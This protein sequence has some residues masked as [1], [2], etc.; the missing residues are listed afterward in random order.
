MKLKS[1]PLVL[2]SAA[3]S[4][5]LIG[6]SEG[7]EQGQSST[8]ESGGK[9]K[10]TF[11]H[12]MTDITGDAVKA[13]I[14]AFEEKNP[15]I[16]IEATYIA[17]QG[18]GQ[19]EK[20]MA[21]VAGGNPPDV[22]YFD[23]FEVGAWA[24][25]GSLEELTALAQK[26]GITK[27]QYY[28][29][30]WEESS[31]QDKLYAIP[32]T[33]DSR[34]VYFNV[35]HFKE[36]G[37]DP[38]NPPKTIADL[39][40]AASKLTK[41]DGK[42]FERIGFIPWFGQGSLYGWGWAFGGEFYDAAANK[43]TANHPK[44]VEALQ[45]LA[46]YAKKYNVEDISAFTDSQGTGAMDPFLTGQLSMKVSGPWEVS[47]IQ[48]FAP[49]LKYGV[50]PMPTPTGGDHTTWSGGWSVVI[51]KGAKQK[52][53]A[54]EFLKYFGSAEGQKVFSGIARDFSVIDSVNAELGFKDDPVLKQFVDILPSSRNRPVMTQGSLYWNELADA[55]DNATRGN[56]TPKE[57]LDKVTD[58]VNSALAK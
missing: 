2:V 21:A 27:E 39:E 38:N 52:D 51:P 34:L 50:F 35:D 5:G 57:I 12:P 17:N 53:A 4:I 42:R 56:G 10:V 11:W 36:A 1:L 48:R 26:S 9:T 45:W 44:N 19:N 41:K 13:V 46:D 37:L 31:Y 16:K 40:E 49:D 7:N 30:A 15:N 55:V 33:T 3:I 54:W 22:A 24:A 43:A 47:A 28:P 18:E 29:F 32:T 6:C 8:A 58:K 23:R 20:L 14:K 25:Q